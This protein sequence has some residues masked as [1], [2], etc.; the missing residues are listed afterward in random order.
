LAQADECLGSILFGAGKERDVLM[1][2]HIAR[3]HVYQRGIGHRCAF[4]LVEL[5]VVI[6]IIAVLIGILL[7]ALQRARAQASLV[8]CQSNLRQIGQAIEIYVVDNQGVMPYGYWNGASPWVVGPPVSKADG[9]T[10]ASDWTTLIQNDFNNQISSA[11]NTGSGTS[12]QNQILSRVRQVFMCPDAPQ[13]PA[14]DPNNLVYQYVCHPRLMPYLGYP[15]PESTTPLHPYRIGKINRSAEIAYVFDG[16][17]GQMNSGAWRVGGVQ[18]MPCGIAISHGWI[19]Y[20]K[21]FG[22]LTDNY[23]MYIFNPCNQGTPVDMTAF[24][25]GTPNTDDGS[26]TATYNSFNIRFRHMQNTVANALMVDGHVESFSFNAKTNQ[27]SL[28]DKNIFVNMQ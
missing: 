10:N 20:S 27:T 8:Q 28:L 9:S 16:T 2:T 5:L 17:L 13:G 14:F 7:P 4:T 26:P 12:M 15:D 21:V 18:G 25:G 24:F 1:R 22:G 3:P 23:S 6:G 19:G 11:Y